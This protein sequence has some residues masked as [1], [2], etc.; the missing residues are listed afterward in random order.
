VTGRS[1]VTIRPLLLTATG[2]KNFV[3]S[4]NQLVDYD[5]ELPTTGASTTDFGIVTGLGWSF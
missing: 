1:F 5:S 2:G 4:D 3:Q